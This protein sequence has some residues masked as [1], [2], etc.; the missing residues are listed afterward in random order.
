MDRFTTSARTSLR[1]STVLLGPIAKVTAGGFRGFETRTFTAEGSQ[2]G[3]TVPVEVLTSVLALAT[4]R[5]GVEAALMTSWDVWKNNQ[6]DLEIHG[7]T[8]SLSLPHPNWH[9]G[10]L[11]YA[12][13]RGSWEVVPLDDNPL[14]QPNWPPEKPLASNYRGIGIAE[15]IDAMEHGQPH[16]VSADL[17]THVVE[18]ADAII[19]SAEGG[20]PVAL[21]T[22]PRRPPIFEPADAARLLRPGT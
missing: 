1:P 8:G 3:M 9:G 13:A 17:A 4:F 15:M 14:A 2:K 18:A 16:R 21:S 7:T 20:E 11:K 10:P 19:S 6:P 12:R 22:A 5:S